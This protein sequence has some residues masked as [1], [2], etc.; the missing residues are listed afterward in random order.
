MKLMF[1]FVPLFVLLAASFAL[2][3]PASAAPHVKV[4]LTVNQSEVVTRNGCALQVTKDT[5][6]LVVVKCNPITVTAGSEA[7]NAHTLNPG[8]KLKISAN[9]CNLDVVK[10][11]PGKVKVLCIPIPDEIVTVG[12]GGAWSFSA[13]TV[14]ISVGETVGWVW[15]SDDHTVTSGDGTA[16]GVFCSPNNKNCDTAPSS[17]T[18]ATYQRTFPVAGTF[19]Y[20]CRIHSG[21][22]G[23]VNVA[24]P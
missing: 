2:Q 16:D 4:T 17:N 9:G 6:A 1:T 21:M 10:S 15:D 12:P 19:E 13:A 14:N 3:P 23:T 11:K 7:V 20:Y 22:T 24:A 8:Q 18:G 5:P